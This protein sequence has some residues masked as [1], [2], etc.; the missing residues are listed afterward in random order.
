MSKENEPEETSKSFGEANADWIASVTGIN[1]KYREWD[2]IYFLLQNWMKLLF[3]PLDSNK[4]MKM[5][6]WLFIGEQKQD[7]LYSS[8]CF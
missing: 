4:P 1:Y 6:Q 8:T 5:Y 3:L 2:F 7:V